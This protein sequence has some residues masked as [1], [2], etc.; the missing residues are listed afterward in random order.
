MAPE[1]QDDILDDD[2]ERKFTHFGKWFDLVCKYVGTT[3]Y[4]V[5]KRGGFS[6]G[7][8]SKATR[9]YT[10]EALARRG[11]APRRVNITR[12]VTLLREMA[13]E[14]GLPWA[15]AVEQKLY[16]SAGYCTPEEQDET[17]DFIPIEE[18][19]EQNKERT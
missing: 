8:L 19:I 9:Y 11:P 5:S 7:T 3:A 16:R 6:P 15:Y 12:V 14:K 10:E 17:K 18:L 2:D 1:Q 4:V 13:A